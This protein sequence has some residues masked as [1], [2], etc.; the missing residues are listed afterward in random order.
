MPIGCVMCSVRGR[1]H[2]YYF[3][4]RILVSERSWIITTRRVEQRNKSWRS[5]TMKSRIGVEK[6]VVHGRLHLVVVPIA[7]ST[8]L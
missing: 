5:D 6:V 1:L 3:S 2:Y 7:T 8:S 4:R